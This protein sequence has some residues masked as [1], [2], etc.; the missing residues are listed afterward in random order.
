MDLALSMPVTASLQ[1]S[2]KKPYFYEDK[3]DIATVDKL[4]QK[5]VLCPNAVKDAY[6]VYVVKT[7]HEKHPDSS[8]LIFSH[9]CRECQALAI[10]LSGLGF[11]VCFLFSISTK[12]SST[13]SFL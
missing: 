13:L 11:V 12:Q 4:E 5:Y 6:L 7:F 8:V 2:L 9:T 3:G 10:M 1:V